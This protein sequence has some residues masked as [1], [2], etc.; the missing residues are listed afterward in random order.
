VTYYAV[1][2]A[3]GPITV[4]LAGDTETEAMA[5]F[6]ELNGQ[7]AIDDCRVDIEDALGIDGADMSEDDFDELL[8]ECGAVI[9][10][11]LTSPW[12]LWEVP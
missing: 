9:C 3:N 7:K 11:G 12:W 4:E 6:E 5:S 8:C 2:D 1:C 10:C